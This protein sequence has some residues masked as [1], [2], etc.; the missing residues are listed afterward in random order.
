V[1]ATDELA[2]SEEERVLLYQRNAE[3]LFSLK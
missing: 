3:R 1:K 2:I